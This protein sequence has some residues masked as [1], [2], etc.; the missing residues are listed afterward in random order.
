MTCLPED[1]N[2][3]SMKR[4]RDLR[5]PAVYENDIREFR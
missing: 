2:F 4:V 3:S 1:N 5:V